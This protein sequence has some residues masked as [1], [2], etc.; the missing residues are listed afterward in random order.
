[1]DRSVLRGYL[2]EP[3]GSLF[4]TAGR[5][6]LMTALVLLIGALAAPVAGAVEAAG[7]I[8]KADTAWVL[9]STALV[10]FMT[11]GLAIFYAGM[12]RKKNVLSTMMQSFFILCLIT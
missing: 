10:M 2:P 7:E 5:G 4:K 12:A 3:P 11:P 8:N 1:M 9:I 6:L